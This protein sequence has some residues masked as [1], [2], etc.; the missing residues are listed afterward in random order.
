MFLSGR[1][2]GREENECRDVQFLE[3]RRNFFEWMFTI[4]A[5]VR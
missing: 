5:W 4:V 2:C 1:C 3:H